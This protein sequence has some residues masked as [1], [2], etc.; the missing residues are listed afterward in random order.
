MLVELMNL[1]A[2]LFIVV[3]VAETIKNIKQK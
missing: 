1:L 2:I 3:A